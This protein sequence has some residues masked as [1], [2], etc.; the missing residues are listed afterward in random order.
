[1]SRTPAILTR[2]LAVCAGVSAIFLAAPR[3]AMDAQQ[4]PDAAALSALEWREI[5]PANSGGRISAI[6][7]LP[8]NGDPFPPTEGAKLRYTELVEE[9][10]QLATELESIVET[11]VAFINK[12]MAG[13]PYITIGGR[14]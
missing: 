12:A 11:E 3:P 2:S 5:G 13:T 8:G 1:M 7:G 9:T 6:V 10:R 14:R 4:G